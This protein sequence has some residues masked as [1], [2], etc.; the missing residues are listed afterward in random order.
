MDEASSDFA[1]WYRT[2]HPRV[3]GVLTVASGDLDASVDATDEAF[4]R[5]LARWPRVRRM[6]SPGGWTT[7][8]ALNVLRR[9][10]RRRATEHGA[11]R[12]AASLVPAPATDPELWDVVRALPERQRIAVVLRF[13]AGYPEAEIAHVMGIR[14][15]TVASTLAQARARLAEMLADD[16]EVGHG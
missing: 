1:A 2:E 7:K 15:G 9:A 6:D 14:R 10:K 11:V 3:I 5:A 12:R 13:V 4:A 16:S 8:V